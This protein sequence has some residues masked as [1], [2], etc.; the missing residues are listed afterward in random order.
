MRSVRPTALADSLGALPPNM[1][2]QSVITRQELT[3]WGFDEKFVRDAFRTTDGTYIQLDRFLGSQAGDIWQRVDAVFRPEV[4]HIQALQTI[5][6]HISMHVHR[7]TE[8]APAL[9]PSDIE[10]IRKLLRLMDAA[11]LMG[12]VG[13]TV[14]HG[15]EAI[16][17]AHGYE[18]A[19]VTSSVTSWALQALESLRGEN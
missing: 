17:E 2:L 14:R 8:P 19:V 18:P 6:S 13:S 4:V 1:L 12:D 5:G 16:V 15:W 3:D 10:G 9:I 11:A 7:H